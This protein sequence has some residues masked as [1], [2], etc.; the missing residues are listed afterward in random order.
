MRLFGFHNKGK[1]PKI[2]ITEADRNWIEE[3][4]SWLIQVFG[5]PTRYR[6]Q[7]LITHKYFPKTFSSEELN[8]QYVI[9]DLC[10]LTGVDSNLISFELHSDLRDVYG[11]PYEIEGKPFETETELT[12]NNYKIHIAKSLSNHPNRLIYGLIYE[13]IKIRL[14]ESNLEFD[15]GED[16][17]LFIFIAGIY[18]G[19]GI[20]L[21][22]NLTD[23][24]RQDDGFWETKWNFI[25]EMP[26]EVMAFGLATYAML[27]DQDNPEWK[28]ELPQELRHLFEGAIVVLQDSPLTISNKAELDASDLFQQA[29]QEYIKGDY[30]SAISILQKILFLTEDELLRADVLNNIGYYQIRKGEIDKS[31]SNFQKAIQIDS[32]YGYAYDNLGYALILTGQIEEGKDQL[33]KAFRTENNDDAYTYRNFGLY[34]K[35]KNEL[36]KSEDNFRLA[37]NSQTTPVDL[38][39]Y[40]YADLLFELGRTEEA[41]KYLKKAVRKGEP[42]AIKKFEIM[43]Q[44][45]L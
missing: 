19:F 1:H 41:M 20:P 23:R 26:N 8:I 21:S 44:R 11:L 2:R 33:E 16:T 6:D 39:E 37:F 15:T 34:Y 42:E 3:N 10:N 36:E 31:I 5:Y 45:Y 9:D 35:A 25:S 38:L 4:F 30:E 24:G 28:N 13:F 27:L 14:I 43:N 7:I 29:D 12:E 32:N 22:Q 17:G 18:F 40:H